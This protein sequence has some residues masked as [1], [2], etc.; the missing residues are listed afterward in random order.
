MH[1]CYGS[2]AA[3][4]SQVEAPVPGGP[5][6]TPDGNAKLVRFVGGQLVPRDDPPSVKGDK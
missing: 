3:G 1:S 2:G 4:C 6:G 5:Q